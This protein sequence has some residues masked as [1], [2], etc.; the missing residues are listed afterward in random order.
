MNAAS[1]RPVDT[2]TAGPDS[3]TALDAAVSLT[4]PAA[5][6]TTPESAAPGSPTGTAAAG[7][8]LWRQLVSVEERK[9]FLTINPLRSWWMIAVNWLGVFAA[10][11]LVAWWPNVVTIVV[12]LFTIAA[13][14]LGM[15]V[16]M[17]EAAHRTLFKSRAWNDW[18]GNWLAA[19]PVWTDT[20][21][22]RNY[23][24][25]HHSK[26]GTFEDPDLG[27]VTPFPITPESFRRKVWRDLSGQTGIKQAIL[28]YKRDM[29]F[30]RRRSQ[31]NFGMSGGER[32]DVGWHKIAPVAITNAVLLAILT[33]A[34]HPA[35]YLLWV[36]SWLTTYRLVTRIRAIAEHSVVPDQL[37]PLRNTRTTRARWWERLLIAPNLVNYHYEHHLMMT[38]P[39]HNLP[40]LHRRL[41]EHGLLPEGCFASG[42]YLEVL[43]L[44]TSRAG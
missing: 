41:R 16:V 20:G 44:A 17:H 5:S 43:R 11:A 30:G 40:K 34:G 42:G 23:H 31:R 27:L 35:L 3:D 28:V 33:L 19:Y 18:A 24:L 8:P 6:T 13:R 15:A 12:A 39:H 2:D 22:Y 10:M 21:P 37:D 14:Q 4:A 36:V 7:I 25:A 1:P 32:A 29:G 9:E 38:V 26:T